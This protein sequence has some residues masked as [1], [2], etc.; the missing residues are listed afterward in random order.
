MLFLDV[1]CILPASFQNP[2]ETVA[3]TFKI[4]LTR[5]FSYFVKGIR[6]TLEENPWNLYFGRH[7]LVHFCHNVAECQE[8]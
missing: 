6:V 4:K 3:R 2:L 1:S 8:R 7:K 5:T